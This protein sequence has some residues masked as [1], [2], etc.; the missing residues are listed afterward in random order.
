[1]H[2][3]NEYMIIQKHFKYLHCKYLHTFRVAGLK[4]NLTKGWR[5]A[6]FSLCVNTITEWMITSLNSR[7]LG[8]IS[9]STFSL[10]I[11]KPCLLNVT[12]FIWHICRNLKTCVLLTLSL[13]NISLPYL[14][15]FSCFAQVR[16]DHS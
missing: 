11:C 9:K 6:S 4:I 13:S 8:D 10:V 14:Q 5:M 15:K 16:L 12:S 3:Y 7:W 1:M 2:I